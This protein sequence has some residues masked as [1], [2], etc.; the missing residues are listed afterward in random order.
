MEDSA[1]QK[2]YNDEPVEYCVHCLSLAIREV[3][4]G[5]YCDKCGCTA[6]A[7]VDI[8]TWESMYENIHG[9]KYVHINLKK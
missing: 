7:K 6:T 1:K 9:A 4:G 8:H 5:P 2:E 3:N